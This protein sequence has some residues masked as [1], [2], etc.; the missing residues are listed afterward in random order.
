M[1]ATGDAWRRPTSAPS[2]YVLICFKLPR[3]AFRVARTREAETQPSE[4]EENMSIVAIIVIV[5]VVV[6]ALLFL[7]RRFG[8]RARVKKREL[9]LRQRRKEIAGKHRE[10][11]ESREREAEAA[12]TRARMAEQEARRER[13]EAQLRHEKA[14]LHER[15][16]ADHELIADHERERFAGTSAVADSGVGPASD[17]GDERERSAAYREGQRAAD[18]PSRAEEFKAGRRDELE[19]RR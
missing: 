4:K 14:T 12:E 1:D 11:A 2:H 7:L 10:E 3:L 15:G 19:D 8:N 18:D 6:L 13:A 9:E 16:M 5:V 17:A